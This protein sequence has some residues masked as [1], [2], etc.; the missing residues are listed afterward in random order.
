MRSINFSSDNLAVQWQYVKRNLGELG[1]LYQF[2]DFELQAHRVVQ[3]M[4]QSCVNEEFAIQIGARRYEHTSRRRDERQGG[5]ERRLTTT[6]GDSTIW[7]PRTRFNNVKVHYSLFERYQRRQKKFDRA[8]LLS[9]LL[10]LSVRKQRRFFKAFIGDAVSHTTA[11]RLIRS[12][13]GDLQAFRTKP[14]KDKYKYLLIDGLWVKI[15][16]SGRLKE[17]VILFV[18]GITV[19]NQKEIISFKVAKGETELEVTA[20]LNDIYRRGL[21]GKSLKIV[22]S[23]GAKGIRAAIQV[24]YPYAK[25]QL[26]YVHKLRNL[27]KHIR[28]KARHRRLMMRQASAIYKTKNRRQA[29]IK[30]EQFCR[31]WQE[32]ESYAVKCFRD[33]FMDTLN[34]F[35]YSDDKNLIS[36]TN[37]LERDLE[38][39]RRRIKIQ[40]YFKSD[41]SAELWVYGIISQFRQ[42]PQP[43]VMP[44]HIIAIFNEPKYKSVQ[45]S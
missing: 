5:Y 9:M 25:W 11:S 41:R 37:H 17:K 27:A 12:L 21:E 18:L 20:L 42:E 34:Y 28:Y 4:I 14:I 19:D 15:K 13:E 30:F 29:V 16:D 45:L 36:S 35:D 6:F 23:D 38:E 40:G 24:V 3:N 32:P 8:V 33:G 7:I 1:I 2:E 44:K 39:V 43:E 31:R 22:A 26:C 10:G